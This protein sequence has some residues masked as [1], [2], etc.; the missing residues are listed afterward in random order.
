[1]LFVSVVQQK[2]IDLKNEYKIPDGWSRM[3]L[4]LI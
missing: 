3:I 2:F 1:M 4:V